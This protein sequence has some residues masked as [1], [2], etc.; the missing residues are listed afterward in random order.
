MTDT[1]HTAPPTAHHD[2]PFARDA[3]RWEKERSRAW[4]TGHIR[5]DTCSAAC[6]PLLVHEHTGW[7][8]LAWTVPAD[9]SSRA[10]L[11]QVAVLAPSATRTQRLALRWLTRRPARLITADARPG[12]PRLSACAV[13]VIS[14]IIGLIA[15]SRGFPVSVGLPAMLLAP[16][17]VEYLPDRLDARARE[18]VRMVE[19]AAACR[20]LQ[21][22][23]ALHTVLVQAA[24]RSDRYELRRSAEIGH[25]LLWDTADLLQTQDT[26]SASA[27]LITRE[28]LMVQ[29]V[30]Q[31]T[32]ILRHTT[33]DGLAGANPDSGP[34]RH[35]DPH[36]RAKRPATD[37]APHHAPSPLLQEGTPLMPQPEPIPVIRSLNVYFL[38]AH[39]PYH[40][41]GAQ[42]INTTV[43]A[44]A[45]LLHPGVRQPDGV[46]IHD[47]LV[48]G[49]RPGEIVPLST[50]THE[51]DGGARW[52]EVGDWEAV[53][54]DLLQLIRDNACDALSLGL[55]Y[56]ARALVCAGPHSEV[57][58]IDPSSGA[59]RVYGPADRIEVLV[60]VGKHL[61][62]AEA[63]SPLWPGHGLLTPLAG[64]GKEPR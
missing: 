50:L 47:H 17:A 13:A 29:L 18:H 12:S 63:G 38:F 37:P 52:P 41:V 36:P 6:E 9:G 26:R 31:V 44:A 53:T 23:G 46:R 8:S 15:I 19:D 5:D 40:P 45:S 28:R 32:Q 51:L 4:R 42:E 33:E 56:I 20:Y 55:P 58:T 14:L 7:G 43:V 1:L 60:E 35:A 59:R 11:H 2:R 22:L 10:N 25:T 54:R 62:W 57:R 16:L 30:H 49:R 64:T 21:R 3:G 39:E 27:Y 24:A 61:A 48:R 34:G